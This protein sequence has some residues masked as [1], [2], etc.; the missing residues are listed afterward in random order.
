MARYSEEFMNVRPETMK[1]RRQERAIDSRRCD[2]KGS[3]SIRSGCAIVQ[4]ARTLNSAQLG[5][6]LLY[7]ISGA[8]TPVNSSIVEMPIASY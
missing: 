1:A 2:R 5:E 6:I 3:N 7:L 4:A 8:A